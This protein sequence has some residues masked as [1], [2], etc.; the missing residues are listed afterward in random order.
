MATRSTPLTLVR[1]AD[2]PLKL[3]RRH[4]GRLVAAARE[5]GKLAE[6]IALT[7]AIETPKGAYWL[8]L[9]AVRTTL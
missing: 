7:A 3:R 5:D 6:A 9:D 8:P 4:G 2:V 1:L